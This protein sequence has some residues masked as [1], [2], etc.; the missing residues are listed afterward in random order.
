MRVAFAIHF[1]SAKILAYIPYLIIKVL[2]IC[3]L[4]TLL[5]LK[6]QGPKEMMGNLRDTLL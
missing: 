6:K 3:L 5:V 1:F 4:T 2:T